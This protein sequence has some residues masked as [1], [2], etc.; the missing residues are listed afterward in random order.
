[1]MPDTPI[2][3]EIVGLGII[4]Y[5]P[6]STAAIREGEDYLSSCFSDPDLVE[7]QALAG[8]IVGVAT[9][10]PGRFQLHP[11]PGYP[12]ENL[13]DSYPHQLRLGV[14][15]RDGGLHVRDL[16]DLLQWTATCPAAQ[17]IPL[18][19]GFYHLT[20]LSRDPASGIMG[21]DQ[22]ILVYY[23]PLSEMPALRYNG[24]PTLC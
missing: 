24:V 23:Q 21:D 11:R 5:S 6:F 17:I 15:V 2:T 22:E 18:R 10:T 16:Y 9:G 13:F 8:R 14:E 7:Q 20:L 4:F 3:L 19:P 12:P 1:M